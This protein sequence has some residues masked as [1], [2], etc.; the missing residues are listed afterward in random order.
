LEPVANTALS[1]SSQGHSRVWSNLRAFCSH[2][3][4]LANALCPF[5]S[6]GPRRWRFLK[7]NP[8]HRGSQVARHPECPVD[9]A[10]VKIFVA[11]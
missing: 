4:L 7:T 8:S 11:R 5:V 3:Q 2:L 1:V 6:M 10:T 9:P